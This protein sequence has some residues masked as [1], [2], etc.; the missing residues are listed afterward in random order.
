MRDVLLV[1]DMLNDFIHKDG[2]LFFQAGADIVP[3]VE[4]RTELISK[5]FLK[6][7]KEIQCQL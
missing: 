1:I 4:S 3:I 5:L 7:F 2:S 6:T